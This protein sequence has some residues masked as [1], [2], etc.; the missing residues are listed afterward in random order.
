MSFQKWIVPLILVLCG[1]WIPITGCVESGGP[2]PQP[3]NLPVVYHVGKKPAT[4]VADDMNNDEFPDLMVANTDDQTLM[5]FEGNGDGTFKKPFVMKTGREPVALATADFNGD[6]IPD[7]AV[8]N[9]GDGNLSIIFGQ[10]DGVFKMMG[11]VKTGKL[12]LAIATGDFNGDRINDLA[13]TLRFDKLIILLGNGDGTFKLAEAYKASGLP[14]RLVVGDYNSDQHLDLAIA[15]N[16]VKTKF[17][18]IYNGRGD[19]TFEPPQRITGGNQSGF[20]AQGDMNVDGHPDLIISSTMAESLTLFL[21]DG[22]GGFERL[23]DFAAEKGPT[24]I[25]AGEFTGDKIPDLI[26]A[27]RRDGT[28]SLLPGRGDGTFVFPHYNYPVGR[29]P[30][31]I[32][33]SDF[34]RDGL[35]DLAILLYDSA[36]LEILMQKIDTSRI[37]S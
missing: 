16:G 10:K 6:R 19:G 34:N 28:I 27:N 17:I 14:A 26:V 31:A 7:I 8:C 2:D 25:V 1:V 24:H 5:F 13:V 37:A 30:R 3:F 22:K 23:Q 12:P 15:F 18:R 11:T 21:G 33:A 4:V 9:Y 32:A 36:V 29:H 35:T 20:I